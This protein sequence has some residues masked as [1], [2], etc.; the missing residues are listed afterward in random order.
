[1]RS[2]APIGKTDT[3]ARLHAGKVA[4]RPDQRSGI[5]DDVLVSSEPFGWEIEEAVTERAE[6]AAHTGTHSRLMIDR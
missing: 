5:L 6:A 3:V 1:M 2:N 4:N